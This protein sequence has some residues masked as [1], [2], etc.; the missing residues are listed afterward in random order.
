MEALFDDGV[1]PLDLNWSIFICVPK[2]TEEDDVP[3]SCTRT[4]STVRTLSLKNC[5]A[6]LIAACADR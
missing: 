2:G 5:D 6:K 1:A 4:A 3:D